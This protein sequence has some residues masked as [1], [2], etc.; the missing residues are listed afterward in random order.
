MRAFLSS[1]SFYFPF[2]SLYQFLFSVN[3]AFHST[4]EKREK[5][6][7][8]IALWRISSFGALM[9][10]IGEQEGKK[11]WWTCKHNGKA[12][13]AHTEM[14][15]LRKKKSHK[16]TRRTDPLVLSFFSS[17]IN[18]YIHIFLYLLDPSHWH[19]I[20][21][22]YIFLLDNKFPSR[23]RSVFFFFL[24]PSDFE[25]SASYSDDAKIQSALRANH[26]IVMLHHFTYTDTQY[27][28]K[29]WRQVPVV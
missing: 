3:D 17:A 15:S 9:P 29:W 16:N 2:D 14:D 10:D 1:N 4:I 26:I 11:R 12:N 21:M 13:R 19:K 5:R 6:L 8:F 27:Q 18:L 28:K 25:N 22:H 20:I 24:Y 7:V 23:C